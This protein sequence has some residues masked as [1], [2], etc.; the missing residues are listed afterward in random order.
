[1]FTGGQ[2]VNAAEY[3]GLKELG[4]L[5]AMITADVKAVHLEARLNPS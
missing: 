5:S 1:M 4:S 3:E 2:G